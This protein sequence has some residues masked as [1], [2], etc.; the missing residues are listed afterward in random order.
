MGFICGVSVILPVE[1]AAIKGKEKSTLVEEDVAVEGDRPSRQL[2]RLQHVVEVTLAVE[3]PLRPPRCP[4]APVNHCSQLWAPAAQI[5]R[6]W[7]V[8]LLSK[9][10]LGKWDCTLWQRRARLGVHHK[11]LDPCTFLQKLVGGQKLGQ[12]SSR[13]DDKG[14]VEV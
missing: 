4:T 11:N 14:G 12:V 1:K 3:N 9:K 6:I 10:H 2:A 13:G 8:V 7:T 5:R